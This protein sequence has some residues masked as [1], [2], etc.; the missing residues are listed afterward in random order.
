MSISFFLLLFSPCFKLYN[1]RENQNSH[2]APT[3]LSL[4]LFSSLSLSLS[5]SLTQ[6]GWNIEPYSL[7]SLSH[8]LF[9]D[10]LASTKVIHWY[11]LAK[12]H[13]RFSIL[14]ARHVLFWVSSLLTLIWV[15]LLMGLCYYCFGLFWFGFSILVAG[16]MIFK[17]RV[18]WGFSRNHIVKLHCRL[19]DQLQKGCGSSIWYEGTRI[20]SQQHHIFHTSGG[21]WQLNVLEY[22]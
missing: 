15:F 8:S 21:K 11:V 4:P 17:L 20:V 14:V 19:W 18:W 12:S 6:I 2:I 13:Y 16:F 5:F 22:F 1:S 9:T 3:L 10:W 7:N